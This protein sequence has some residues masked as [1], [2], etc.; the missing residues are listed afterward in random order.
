M[1][2]LRPAGRAEMPFVR[3]V[4]LEAFPKS[5]RKP[6]PLIRRYARQ[7]LMELLVVCQQEQMAGIAIP[8][9]WQDTVLLDYFAMDQHRRGGGLGSQAMAALLDRYDGKNLFLEIESTEVPCDNPEQR[10]S[11]KAFYLRNGLYDTG[12]RLRL[13]GVEMEVL[14]NNAALPFEAC[15]GVYRQLYGPRFASRAVQLET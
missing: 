5:E 7:G 14:A 10:Q 2:D 1:I 15:A 4:Y 11:R 3:Q 6:M 13:F 8:A 12:H 9:I